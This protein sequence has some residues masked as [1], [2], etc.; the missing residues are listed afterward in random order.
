M[1]LK[2]LHNGHNCLGCLS[3]EAVVSRVSDRGVVGYPRTRTSSLMTRAYLPERNSIEDHRVVLGVSRFA[4][5][6]EIKKS[7]RRLALELHP[8]VCSG[9]H[10]SQRFQ[11]VQRA[12]EV[13]IFSS[14]M[15]YFLS[16]VMFGLWPQV[17]C[18]WCMR[19]C[20]QWL[21]SSFILGLN[22]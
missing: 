8:D 10:C 6:Q 14:C 13:T 1:D 9:D 20:S 21:N 3:R 7:Y 4:T 5:K 12:Y 18:E 2:T 19:T 22:W 17:F 16:T 11:Q 15:E